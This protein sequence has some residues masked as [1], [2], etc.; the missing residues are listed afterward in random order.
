MRNYFKARN[1]D[2]RLCSSNGADLQDA[3]WIAMS[4]LIMGTPTNWRPVDRQALLTACKLRSV[5]DLTKLQ[6]LLQHYST[7]Y[8][9]ET[10]V[11]TVM[12]DRRVL[13]FLKKFPYPVK[14]KGS[15]NVTKLAGINKFLEAEQQCKETNAKFRSSDIAVEFPVLEK[16]RLL[17]L[18]TLPEMNSNILKK[19]FEGG[20]H[21]PGATTVNTAKAGKTTSYY[22]FLE[23][24]YTCTEAARPYALAAISS[25]PRWINHLEN[26]GRR[27]SIPFPGTP[28]WLKERQ[29]FDSCVKIEVHDKITFVPK[30]A[31][32]DR[33]IALSSNMNMFLQL[34]VKAVLMDILKGVG[35]D[36]T[37]QS[38]N[39]RMAYDGSRYSLLNGFLNPNQYSTIDLAS[40]SDTI[41]LE[42]VRF[43]LPPMWF[44]VLMDLR[45]H[46]GELDQA[47]IT[48]E[49]FC[50]MG[51]G[52]TFP[53]ESLIFWAITKTSVIDQ[54]FTCTVNDIAV[55][56]D[57]IIVRYKATSGVILQLNNAGFTINKE[58]SFISGEFKESCGADY[59][60][61]TNVRPFYLKRKLSSFSDIYFVCN[62]LADKMKDQKIRRGYEE[63]Y[64]ALLNLI[65]PKLRNY[66]PLSQTVDSI[67][68]LTITSDESGL[69][70]PLS[71]LRKIGLVPY[72]TPSEHQHLCLKGYFGKPTKYIDPGFINGLPVYLRS[73]LVPETYGARQDVR[74]LSKFRE[75]DDNHQHLTRDALA[76][77]EAEVSGRV[78]RRGRYSRRN[79]AV[80]CPSWDGVYSMNEVRAHLVHSI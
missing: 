15:N 74:Y 11:N 66:I 53:L 14:G 55:Y 5:V 27:E 13:A 46:S 64:I 12:Y 21:G 71:Y 24:P 10:A 33:P 16:A 62:S 72:L 56:G 76:C 58:K 77:V 69:S 79:V 28:Q 26:T 41:S 61:G 25:D 40:A 54:G 65:P 75:R 68:T 9:S 78:T 3:H 8:C 49:K 23:L 34:G 32:T 38:K 51:N 17:L 30:D 2:T 50:A 44:A 29:L 22:K 7:L 67:T 20:M 47:H 70:V 36:L 52:Y 4:S 80:A 19:I 45:H 35:V 59:F 57:D 73:I 42:L 1:I 37:D 6:G 18:R 63:V 43:L 39:Q 48:Y 60:R 31:L